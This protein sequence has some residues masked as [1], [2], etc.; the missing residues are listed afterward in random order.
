MTFKPPFWLDANV[1]IECKNRWYPFARVPRFWGFLSGKIEEGSIHSPKAVYDELIEYG[2]QLSTWVKT[3]KQGLCIQPV[4]GIQ[5]CYRDIANHVAANFPREKAEEFLSDADPW[6]IASAWFIGGTVVTHESTSR[7]RK[8][9][10][11]V[12]CQHFGVPFTDIV[13][14][15]DHFNA[16]L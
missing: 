14:V 8:I 16:V 5:T 15:L 1:Y 11:P 6:V 13:A 9:R 10:I 7:R 2:D 4:D 3:R 12:I